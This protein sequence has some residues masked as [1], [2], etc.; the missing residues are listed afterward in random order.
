MASKGNK[1][2]LGMSEN[3]RPPVFSTAKEMEDSIDAYF[4]SC[5][6]DEGDNYKYRPT[7]T[8]LALF[9]GF[10]SRQSLYDYADKE[11]FSYIIKRAKQVV[12]MS[13]EEMLLSRSSTGAIFALKNMGWSDKTEVETTIKDVTP[14]MIQ[15]TENDKDT[16]EV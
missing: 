5:L 8:G 10:A 2:K 15:F 16:E 13:Y 3:G 7:I 9:I 14:L 11:G 1:F 4:E 6:D 12:A